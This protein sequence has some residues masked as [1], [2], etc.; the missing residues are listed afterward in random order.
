LIHALKEGTES[1]A[2]T[3]LVALGGT[4]AVLA[5]SWVTS[6]VGFRRLIASGRTEQAKQYTS[7]IGSLT[8]MVLGVGALVTVIVLVVQAVR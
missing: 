1:M 8:G 4:V 3:L 7:A 5:L 6:Y 2:T